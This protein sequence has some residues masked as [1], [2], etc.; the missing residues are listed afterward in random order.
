MPSLRRSFYVFF[1]S[2]E[3]TESEVF[4]LYK[5][6]FCYYSLVGAAITVIVGIFVSYVTGFEDV[7]T[8]NPRYVAPCLREWLKSRERHTKVLVQESTQLQNLL[9]KE[10]ND[11]PD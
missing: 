3:E 8:L 11:N 7:S 9:T 2:A 5:L 1:R 4:I 6:S 10:H